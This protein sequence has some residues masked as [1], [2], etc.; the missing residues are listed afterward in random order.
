VHYFNYA[1]GM[2]NAQDRERRKNERTKVLADAHTVRL[3]KAA[4]A[5]RAMLEARKAKPAPAA[6]EKANA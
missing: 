2:L 5:K 4:E 3:E 1:K 6:E